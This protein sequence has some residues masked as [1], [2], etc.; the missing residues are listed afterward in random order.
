MSNRPLRL[1]DA[2]LDALMTAA[3]PIAPEQRDAFLQ[4]VADALQGCAEVGPGNVF[5]VCRELQGRYWHAPDLSRANDQ[6]K[7]R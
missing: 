3:Q 2:E 5:R 1:T 4:A 6:S 7:Y